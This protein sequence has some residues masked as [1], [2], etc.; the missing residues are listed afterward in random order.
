MAYTAKKV[1]TLIWAGRP[2]LILRD[3]SRELIETIVGSVN[4]DGV[5]KLVE[6]SSNDTMTWTDVKA[7]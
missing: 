6:M 2:G 1:Q 4:A 5:E 3:N 7:G